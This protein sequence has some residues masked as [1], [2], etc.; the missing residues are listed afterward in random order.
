MCARLRVCAAPLSEC[1]STV[2]PHSG[3]SLCPAQSQQN[4]VPG[5]ESLGL[6]FAVQGLTAVSV[7]KAAAHP[8]SRR[9]SAVARQLGCDVG[10][11]RT[12]R[13]V[14]PPCSLNGTGTTGV[15]E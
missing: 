6:R 7:L 8:R 3:P 13:L 12:G 2:W 10:A 9:T 14:P 11:G 5:S 15:S 4:S 1:P